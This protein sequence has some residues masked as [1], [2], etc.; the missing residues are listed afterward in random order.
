[1]RAALHRAA[2]T[3]NPDRGRDL[4]DGRRH[5]RHAAPRAGAHA[6]RW[7]VDELAERA[8]RP[9]RLRADRRAQR[10][11]LGGG[12]RVGPSELYGYDA[13]G[14][15][16]FLTDA[17]GN[18]TDTYDYDAWG[19]LVGRMGSTPNTRL[20]AGEEFDPDL[21]LTNLRARLY[22]PDSGRLL[23]LDPLPARPPVAT[24][25]YLYAAA[26]PANRRDP[27]GLMAAE[28]TATLPPAVALT[29]GTT[30]T[31]GAAGV[32][33][34]TAILV[35]TVAGAVGIV[36]ACALIEGS[37]ITANDLITAGLATGSPVLTALAACAKTMRCVYNPDK[38]SPM[39]ACI[40]DC[41]DGT[42]RHLPCTNGDYV[43]EPIES[44]M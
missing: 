18:L 23:T 1:M 38:G 2:R 24:N 21:G 5:A 9:P 26:D 4:H 29:V 10:T 6:S 25:R 22:G 39:G 35:S 16:T 32:T 14:N 34:G 27:L 40:Y 8:P 36:G 15:V 3:G 19:L 13:H 42:V 28:Y 33:A 44:K 17:T 41:P 31:V 20:Y 43:D 12:T 30:V 37:G 7:C 11:P